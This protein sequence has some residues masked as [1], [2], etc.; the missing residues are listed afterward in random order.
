M[1]LP[2]PGSSD[3]L[4]VATA[5][6]ANVETQ[7]EFAGSGHQL[8]GFQSGLS[9]SEQFNKVWRQSST[10]AAVVAELLAAITGQNVLDDGNVT[11]KIQQ[12]AMTLSAST[13]CGVS[14]SAA[15]AQTL[16]PSIAPTAYLAGAA[17]RF[18]ATYSNTGATTLNI[19]GLGAVAV[20]KKTPAGPVALTGG[21]IVAGNEISVVYDG[22]HFQLSESLTS[23]DWCGTSG[24]SANAQTLTPASALEAYVTGQSFRFLAGFTNTGAATMNISG[25]GAVNIFAK[26]ATGPVALLG[27]E[28]VAG[29]EVA[30]TFDGTQFQLEDVPAFPQSSLMQNGYVKL[31]GGLIFQWGLVDLNTAAPEDLYGPYSFPIPFPNACL[32]FQVTTY[33]NETTGF[34]NAGDD[35]AMYAAA[36]PPTTTQFWFWLNWTGA[37]AVNAARGASWFAIGF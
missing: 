20:Y 25:L 4:P 24:G 6:G 19:S 27:G 7:G 34:T 30:I 11:L 22:T 37:P 31:P 17:F 32:N 21:E 9:L 36:N 23:S 16:T 1:P 10:I 15:N 8:T 13:F 18:I 12:L 3:F 2:V 35:I 33:T 28:I 26:S 5:V 14:A 29:N